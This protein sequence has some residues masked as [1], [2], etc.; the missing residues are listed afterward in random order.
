MSEFLQLQP[1]AK[2]QPGKNR[3]WQILFEI[4]RKYYF[5]LLLSLT[6]TAISAMMYPAAAIICGRMFGSLNQYNSGS[7]SSPQMSE[8]ISILC[9]SLAILGC[10]SWIIE[11]GFMSSWIVY[12]EGQAMK[13]RRR[14]FKALVNKDMAWYDL[15]EDG[16]GSL[17][18]RFET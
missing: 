9:F 5:H 10:L 15:R 18:V 13:T 3:P 17:L 7:I 2:K 4:S 6:S 14:L 12:G 11:C 16:I 8:D 1:I